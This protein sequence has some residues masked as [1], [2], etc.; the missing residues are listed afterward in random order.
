MNRKKQIQEQ[1]H[2]PSQAMRTAVVDSLP[3]AMQEIDKMRVGLIA[4]GGNSDYT[5][6][7]GTVLV[8]AA[9]YFNGV[10]RVVP[11][12][13]KLARAGRSRG[14]ASTPGS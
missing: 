5:N 14:P 12:M 11:P 8:A 3:F 9:W 1:L 2:D 4:S 10:E 7:L 6:I 13:G